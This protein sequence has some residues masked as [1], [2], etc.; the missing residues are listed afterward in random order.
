VAAA[1]LFDRAPW[2]ERG[3]ET[4]RAARAHAGPERQGALDVALMVMLTRAD[5]TAEALEIAQRLRAARPAA[6]LLWSFTAA[7]LNELGRAAEVSALAEGR[8]ASRADDPWALRTLAE[9]ASGRSSA[10]DLNN[11]AWTAALRGAVDEAAL[12]WAQQAVAQ[13][14]DSS[15]SLHTLA[16]LYAEAGRVKEAQQVLAQSIAARPDG[17]ARSDDWYVVGR[18]AEH[19]GLGAEAREAY[20]RVD[21][22]PQPRLNGTGALA[23]RRLA[24]LAPARSAGRR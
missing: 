15:A 18:L 1:S 8:L 16:T 22:G 6:D 19:C 11:R 4:L 7:A 23:R 9:Q 10:A 24:G 21:D 14:P 12:D 3:L 5:R 2:L 17:A 20:A 13:E